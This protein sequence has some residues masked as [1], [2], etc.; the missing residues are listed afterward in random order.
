MTSTITPPAPE[1]PPARLDNGS[2][3][4]RAVLAATGVALAAAAC[5]PA[6]G[7][8][9]PTTTTTPTPPGPDPTSPPPPAPTTLPP[10]VPPTGGEGVT[11]RIAIDKLTFG[12]RPGL[13]AAIEARG[14][15]GWIDDQLDPAGRNVAHAEQRV[16]GYTTL[17]N[18]HRQN[19]DVQDSDGGWDRII[20]ELDHAT[21]QRAVYSDRQLYEVMCDFWTNHFNTWRQK[22]WMTFLKNRSH[23]T[24]VRP[25][26]LGKFSTMLLASAQDTAMLDYLDNL[27]SDASQPGGVNENYARELM[28]LHT[29]GMVGG[30]QPFTEADVR[31][32]AKIISGWSINWDDNANRYNF[33]FNPWQHSRDAVTVLGGA[34]TRP[35]RTYGQGYDDGVRLVNLLAH[36]PTTAR[37]IA[38]KLCRRFV[39]DTPS[40]ALVTS[41]AAVF[42]ANDT[43]IAP[44][45]RH[46]FASPE[47][48]AGHK[49]K[50]RRP[51]EHLVGALRA[52]DA[53]MPTAAQTQTTDKLRATLENLGQ[54]IFERHSPDGY[55]DVN[56]FWVSSEGFLQRWAMA[57][58]LARNRLTDP[59]Q[60]DAIVVNLPALLPS[61]A[62]ATVAD[63]IRW[64]A[65]NLANS[66]IN[67][68]DVADLCT[69]CSFSPTAASTTVSGDATKL[70]LAVG[71]VLC[72]PTFQQ[73]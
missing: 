69:A 19:Y 18:T 35:A 23:E 30:V 17:T 14:V 7:G 53:T 9:A 54:P 51:F 21:I 63:L 48:V 70:A 49:R 40:D 1:A 46:I 26:A 58:R 55:P 28:E 25:N 13:A 32:V 20:E 73:R 45:L 56:T 16:S 36:H 37:H 15:W 68:T 67:D 33:R 11:A 6:N 29:L 22:T 41:T 65:T 3:S 2:P 64:V 12:P 39:S 4:R 47:F 72:H 61:P 43:A 24:V 59:G 38:W 27:P 50:V 71:L 10:T 62:P 60:P 42:T 31:G 66:P 34:F 52:L 5:A 8:G 57:G 44:T